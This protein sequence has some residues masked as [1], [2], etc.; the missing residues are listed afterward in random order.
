MLRWPPP[1]PPPQ[2]SV[3]THHTLTV[4]FV[5]TRMNH[6][7][8]VW[9]SKCKNKTKHETKRW[10]I[11]NGTLIKDW[12]GALNCRLEVSSVLENFESS[13]VAQSFGR[14]CYCSFLLSTSGYHP[15]HTMEQYGTVYNSVDSRSFTTGYRI[16][17]YH[18]YSQLWKPSRN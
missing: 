3:R 15:V 13:N 10:R 2:H 7:T 14:Y 12:V 1:P 11:K 5:D 9:R 4:V 18:T 6:V 8:F 17:Q 16:R